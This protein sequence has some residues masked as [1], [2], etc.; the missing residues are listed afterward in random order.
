MKFPFGKGQN[1]MCLRAKN[2]QT[3]NA[4]FICAKLL[5]FVMVLEKGTKAP[6]FTAQALVNNKEET[7]SLQ[8]FKGKKSSTLFLP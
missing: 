5:S 8:D 1:A 7:I 6:N 4:I 3:G 2:V